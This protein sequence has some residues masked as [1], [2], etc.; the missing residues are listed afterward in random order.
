[1]SGERNMQPTK[2]TTST[3]LCFCRKRKACVNWASTCRHKHVTKKKISEACH[4]VWRLPWS[5]SCRCTQCRP[6]IYPSSALFCICWCWEEISSCIYYAE[7]DGAFITYTCHLPVPSSTTNW[8]SIGND[9]TT[10]CQESDGK[11]RYRVLISLI[12]SL[13][14]NRA[15][16]HKEQISHHIRHRQLVDWIILP[17]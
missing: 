7:I 5:Y 16:N 10:E 4:Y 6:A 2:R 3:C 12:N 17:W 15:A 11:L 14:L 9:C 8:P 1:M 13:P